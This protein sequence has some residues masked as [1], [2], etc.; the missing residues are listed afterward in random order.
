MEKPVRDEKTKEMIVLGAVR[1]GISK[2]GRIQK[3]SDLDPEELN[4]I[5]E[6]LEKREYIEVREKKGWLGT[7]IEITATENGAKAVD[8]QVREMQTKWGQMAAIYK[9]G[10]KGKMKGYMDN[11][12]SI[13]PMMI[14]FG[15]MD[16]MMFSMMFSMMG[17][18]MSGYVPEESMPEGE[19]GGGGDD[20]SD[21]SG[22][23]SD[24]GSSDG[25]G[26]DFD[27]GF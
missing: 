19:G 1:H 4:S 10:D 20:M 6:T 16:M 18:P 8:D 7:K 25:G 15:V 3:M 14:F 24:M 26:M 11:N 22:G 23:D 17:M 13:L 12:R 21:S 27:I 9:T 2:F 5:L